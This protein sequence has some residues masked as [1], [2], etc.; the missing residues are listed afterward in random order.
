M[1]AQS[2]I[3]CIHTGFYVCALE[4]LLTLKGFIITS[5]APSRLSIFISFALYSTL[6]SLFQSLIEEPNDGEASHSVVKQAGSKL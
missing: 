4:S 2:V 6:V 5:T 1:V 3:L